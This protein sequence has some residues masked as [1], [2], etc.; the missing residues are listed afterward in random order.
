MPEEIFAYLRANLLNTYKGKN[1]EH[2]LI[3]S[4]V[5]AEFEM[6][7]VACT[8][9]L[10]RGLMDQRFKT[11]LETDQKELAENGIPWRKRCALLHRKNVK[12]ILRANMNYCEI[13]MRI[14]T[15]FADG[16]EFKQSYMKIVEE[17]ETDKTLMTNRIV[18][19]KY[20]RELIV[21]QKRVLEVAKD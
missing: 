19:R 7:V 12:E 21:N 4:P 5:D 15:R 10:F 17:Y 3:S 20:L 18:M 2:L 14:L 1:F 13:L 6:L 11:P 9:N 16:K 8:L